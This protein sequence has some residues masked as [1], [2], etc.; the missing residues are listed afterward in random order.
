MAPALDDVVLNIYDLLPVQN[1][2]AA[3]GGGTTSSRQT[4]SQQQQQ[5]VAA[6]SSFF[7]RFL[8]PIGFG[9]YHTS[10]D[11]RGFRYTFGASVGITRTSAS[12]PSDCCRFLPPNGA[13]KQ[14]ITLGQT[15]FDRGEINAVVQRMREHQFKEGHY[16][17]ANRNCN[18]FS[19]TFATALILNDEL[20]TKDSAQL[21][22]YPPWINRLARTGTSLGIN[23]G[24]VCN[25]A[26]EARLAAGVDGKVGWDLRSALPSCCGNA[27]ASQQTT[28]GSQKKKELTEKQKAALAKLKKSS[29]R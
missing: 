24:H 17:M 20:I 23:D 10:I 6:A 18:H 15:R 3:D 1:E 9:A 2:V 16:H 25:V 19:E 13:F 21:K 5:Q 4:Q 12:D 7:S 22:A 14:S 28:T 11:V 8:S 27:S 26:E 29:N